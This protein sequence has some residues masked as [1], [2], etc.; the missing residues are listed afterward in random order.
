M[1][2]DVKYLDMK[3]LKSYIYLMANPNPDP[4]DHI[5]AQWSRERPDLDSAGFGIAGRL[6]VLGKRLGMRV[7]QALAPLD[8]TRWAFDV[9]ATLRRHGPPDRMTPTELTRATML[10]SGAMTNRIDR[11]E[12][13][14]LVRREADPDDRRGIRVV[15]TDE[16]RELADRGIAARFA[17]ATDVAAKLSVTERSKLESLL[18]KLLLELER[19]AASR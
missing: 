13:R 8:M 18:H 1:K 15:L 5:R 4:I 3:L 16:G 12:A 19:D 11:L 14:G 6:Q 2:F 17:D 10:T 9:L 7:E